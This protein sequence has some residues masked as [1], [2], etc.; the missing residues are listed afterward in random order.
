MLQVATLFLLLVGAKPWQ[1]QTRSTARA[2]GVTS[3]HAAGRRV[4]DNIGDAIDNLGGLAERVID[5]CEDVA[6]A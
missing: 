1:L 2:A 3:R 4:V 6:E 5:A